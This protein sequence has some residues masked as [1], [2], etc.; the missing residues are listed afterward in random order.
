[1]LLLLFLLVLQNFTTQDSVILS[2]GEAVAEG[3]AV[4]LVLVVVCFSS[5]FFRAAGGPVFHLLLHQKLSPNKV[6][7]TKPK[8]QFEIT[9]VAENK[10]RW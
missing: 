8:D 1:M 7:S 2:E 4:A 10:G 9:E 5:S 3:P 6:Q